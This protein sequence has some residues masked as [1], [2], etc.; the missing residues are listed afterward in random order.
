MKKVR[1]IST[2]VFLIIAIASL[3]YAEVPKLINYQGHLTDKGGNPITG[4]S[5]ITFRIYD[6]ESG[7]SIL[8]SETQIGVSAKNGI[9]NVLLGSA[10]VGGIPESV[11]SA[12]NRWL[13]IIVGNDS[14]MSPR[15]QLMSVPYAYRAGSVEAPSFKTYDSGWFYVTS[16]QSYN[17]NHNLGTTKLLINLYFATDT[18][19][20]NM[21]VVPSLEETKGT[22]IGNNGGQVTNITPTSLTVST[23]TSNV[24][25]RIIYGS[26]TMYNDGY[27]RVIAVAL[28]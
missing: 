10:T 17:F 13:G 8:W 23:S 25:R 22:G 5:N 12:T 27:Y 21:T 28:E 14:E 26:V 11:F 16:S 24:C 19:G 6:A 2:V 4:N 15:Q 7:G 9:F 3:S 20:S 1:I 18:S